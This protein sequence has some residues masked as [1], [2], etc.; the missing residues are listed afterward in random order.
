MNTLPELSEEDFVGILWGPV[1]HLWKDICK[2]I[3]MPGL[4]L[5]HS[6]KYAPKVDS[7][8]DWEKF[9]IDSYMSHELVD[10]PS[11]NVASKTDKIKKKM[12]MEHLNMFDKHICLLVF[13][14]DDSE[15]IYALIRKELN[16]NWDYTE[17]RIENNRLNLLK[18]NFSHP[19]NIV[20]DITRKRFCNDSNLMAYHSGAYGGRKRLMH[21]PQSK[22]GCDSLY[23]FLQEFPHNISVL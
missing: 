10:S 3:Q 15:K 9:V 7:G 11:L 4:D 16:E 17:E 6:I 20:K 1:E 23:S 18:K 19:L 5:K 14:F 12:H 22:A 2:S 8:S 13:S 21:T